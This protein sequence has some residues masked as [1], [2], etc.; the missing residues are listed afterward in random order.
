MY[1]TSTEEAW[2]DCFTTTEPVHP[3]PA[4]LVPRSSD[5]WSML[6]VA[7]EHQETLAA[8]VEAV[9]RFAA[10]A[11]LSV[12]NIAY[13]AGMQPPSAS[14]RG[15]GSMVGPSVGARSRSAS[16]IRS[17]SPARGRGGS[18]GSGSLDPHRDLGTQSCGASSGS[19]DMTSAGS[20]GWPPIY[21]HGWMATNIVV[22]SLHIV[23]LCMSCRAPL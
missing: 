8:M 7:E 9:P 18:S 4:T 17:R 13:P 20:Y 6:V 3:L 21:L 2:A 22:H 12:S 1:A 5:A 10:A 16:P 15:R 14:S 11:G 19:T 23:V